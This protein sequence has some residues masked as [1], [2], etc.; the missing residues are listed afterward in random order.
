MMI[1]ML[2]ICLCDNNDIYEIQDIRS[3][4][5]LT[6]IIVVKNDIV[7]LNIYSEFTL[8]KCL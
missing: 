6:A 1:V 3:M 8:Y 7:R 5:G 2:E 4:S